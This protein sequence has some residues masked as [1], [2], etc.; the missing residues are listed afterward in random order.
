MRYKYFQNADVEVSEL[1]LGTW[2]IGGEGWGATD[3]KQSIEAVHA[4]LDQG[5]NLIDTA[6]FYGDGYSEK[7]IGEAI[8]GRRNQVMISTKFGLNTLPNGNCV[9]NGSKDNVFKEIEVSLKNL[10]TDYIDF[11]FMH[12]PDPQ[13]PLCEAMTA[14]A[15][16]KKQ[17]KIRF[18]GVSN[19]SEEQIEEAEK[20]VKIDVQQPQYSML[21]R[22]NEDL[23][24]WGVERGINA[25]AYG[26]MGAGILS[27]TIR[28]KPDFGPD[29]HRLKFY[30]FFVEPKFSK[31][32]ELLKK[33][34]EVAAAHD[35]PVAQVV[36]NWNAQKPFVGTELVGVRSAKKALQNCAAFEWRLSDQE[37]AEIDAEILRLH[38]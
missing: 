11:Y 33:L 1:S 13:T 34:D 23:M 12:W 32:M 38:L 9:F 31:T 8:K 2:G 21:N 24:R 29:D 37:I 19:F 15:E 6:P 4:M 3:D 16:L 7:V 18:V 35:R 25:M 14:L 10:Q 36:I 27:G 30:D 28:E 17:G 22:G 20:Y 26:A 5:V